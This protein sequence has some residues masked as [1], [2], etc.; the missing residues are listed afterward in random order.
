MIMAIPRAPALPTITS[1]LQVASPDAHH[2][3]HTFRSASNFNRVVDG[4]IQVASEHAGDIGNIKYIKEWWED[5]AIAGETEEFPCLYIL[6]LYPESVKVAKDAPYKAQPYIG[7]PLAMSTFPI[8]VMGYYKY[9]DV[10]QPT[11]L[12]R[13]Y[14]YNF[15]DILMAHQ[16]DRTIPAGVQMMTPDVGWY[17]SGTN[18]VVMWW[19]MRLKLSAIL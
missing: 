16:V 5:P 17:I 9:V 10:K 8:T 4:L 1:G 14:A 12:V 15:W 7:D 6:P 3:T 13:D 19:S 11:R 18:Y 2:G